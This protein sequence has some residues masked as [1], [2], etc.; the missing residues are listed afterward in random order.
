MID[1]TVWLACFHMMTQ[2]TNRKVDFELG[3][4]AVLE[5][6]STT[7]ERIDLEDARFLME[8]LRQRY[9][10][11]PLTACHGDFG[12][13]NLLVRR[14][15]RSMGGPMLDIS[16]V[17]DWEDFS[18]DAN[19]VDDLFHYA[20]TYGLD[21]P[22]IPYRKRSPE[23][24]FRLAFLEESPVSRAI[25]TSFSVYCDLTGIPVDALRPLFH[26]FL[27]K[28]WHVTRASAEDDQRWLTF[29]R[30]LNGARAYVFDG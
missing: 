12:S 13:W 28:R 20:V 5:A 17:V 24:A 27:L 18:A 3:K 2:S 9:L 21:Y 14:R 26:F 30:V 29:H 25:R 11:I 10:R 16:G 15:R 7:P 8:P 6:L 19:P 22:W 1:G 4:A 23:E